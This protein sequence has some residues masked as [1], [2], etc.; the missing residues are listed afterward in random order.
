MSA[1]RSNGASAAELQSEERRHGLRIDAAYARLKR[2]EVH[3]AE[4]QPYSRAH[5]EVDSKSLY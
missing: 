4:Y 1:A 3:S 5:T 2:A